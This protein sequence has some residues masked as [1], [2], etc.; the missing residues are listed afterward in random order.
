MRLRVGIAD[1]FPK[2]FT[3]ESIKPASNTRTVKLTVLKK[4]G[5]HYGVVGA[6]PEIERAELIRAAGPL[7]REATESEFL[8]AAG[9]G[10][11]PEESF[12]RWL[13]Q[14]YLFA[15]RL[16]AFQSLLLARAPR[17][18]HGVLIGGLTALDGELSWFE[19][20]ATRLGPVLDVDPLPTCRS[21]TDYLT[22][23]AY[24]QPFA[25]LAAILFG[26]EASYLA[27]WSALEAQGPYREFMERW[28][29]AEFAQYVS[30]L[31]RLAEQ[32]PDPD[33]QQHFNRVL[34]FERDF[35]SMACEG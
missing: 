22:C 31:R 33:Q 20:H 32:H 2:L 19:S 13:A 34:E 1:V 26:V 18:G 3:Y 9:D 27:A 5:L 11:L 21:Y 15:G 7:W 23:C 29:S 14:D 10:S 12:A 35:W 4:R 28:S 17:Q 16:M 24:E 30:A 8:Q 6:H 25:V